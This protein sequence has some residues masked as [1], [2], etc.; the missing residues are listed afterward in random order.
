MVFYF[1]L[2][3]ETSCCGLILLQVLIELVRLIEKVKFFNQSPTKM[4]CISV[5]NNV[6]GCLASCLIFRPISTFDS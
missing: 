6:G 1:Y 4:F 3:I 2:I 5:F